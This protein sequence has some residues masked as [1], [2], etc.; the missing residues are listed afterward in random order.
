MKA[1][2]FFVV[3]ALSAAVSTTAQ[4][5][6]NQ[7]L[8]RYAQSLHSTAES[9]VREFR[10]EVKHRPICST[11]REFLSTIN[12]MESLSDRFYDGAAEGESPTCLER[13]F[14]SMQRSFAYAEQLSR[15]IRL[16]SCVRD[17]MG[18]FERTL[19]SVRSSGLLDA[20]SAP[21]YRERDD[22]YYDRGERYQAPEYRRNPVAKPEEALLQGLL[23]LL[24]RR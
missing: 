21:I 4:A 23:N 11:E 10:E 14:C 7:E 12:T 18:K 5:R 19:C 15:S 1:S 16:C 22:R 24:Q 3:A 17:L 2:V 13:S 6:C 8:F 20:G 9:L